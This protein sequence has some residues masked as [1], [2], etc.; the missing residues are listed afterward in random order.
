MMVLQKLIFSSR[1][2]RISAIAVMKWL[3]ILYFPGPSAATAVY[4]ATAAAAAPPA[5]AAGA[6]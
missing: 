2:R 5:T 6:P 4:A 1:F 3:N